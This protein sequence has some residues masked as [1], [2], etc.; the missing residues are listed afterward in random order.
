M[1]LG[2]RPRTSTRP[3]WAAV[4][5]TVSADERVKIRADESKHFHF[6]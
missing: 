4:D 1:R 2:R 6:I 3:S 5:E